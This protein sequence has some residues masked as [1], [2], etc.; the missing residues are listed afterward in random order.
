MSSS[1]WRDVDVNGFS[2]KTCL[3]FSSAARARSK[4]AQ[5]GATTAPAADSG[6]GR[7]PEKAAGDDGRRADDGVL[8]DDHLGEDR[9]T[10]SNRSARL[11]Q[12]R[13]N[14]PV[15]CRLQLAGRRRRS[16][17][18]VVDERDTVPDEYMVF[19]GDTLTD[20]C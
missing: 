2:T 11:H 14:V 16:R 18:C 17:I 19:D 15:R 12:R 7:T 5:T 1:A 4:W 10:R 8:A 9:R 20:E 3:P 13:F 6:D